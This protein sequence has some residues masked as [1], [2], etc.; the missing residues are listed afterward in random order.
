VEFDVELLGSCDEVVA[1]LCRLAGW[2]FKHEMIPKY[3]PEVIWKRIEGPGNRYEFTT[4]EKEKS[5]Q[6]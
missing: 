3:R 2:T 4:K 5:S 1:E 6:K